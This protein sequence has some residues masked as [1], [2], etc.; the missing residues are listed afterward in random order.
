MAQYSPDQGSLDLSEGVARELRGLLS[1]NYFNTA[2][3]VALVRQAGASVEMINW[4]Q[5]ISLVWGDVLAAAARQGKLRPLLQQL[6]DRSDDALAEELRALLPDQEAGEP[7]TD[8]LPPMGASSLGGGLG[9][10]FYEVV[11]AP[12]LQRVVQDQGPLPPES[13]QQLGIQLAE[14]LSTIHAAGVI[15]RDLK[16]ANIVLTEDGPRIIDFGIARMIDSAPADPA[17]EAGTVM[18][19][20]GFMAPELARGELAGPASDVFGLGV[21]LVYAA[22]GETPFGD[23]SPMALLYRV[24]NEPPRLDRVP[25]VLRPAIEQMLSK[26]PHNRPTTGQLLRLLAYQDSLAHGRPPAVSG[27]PS[28]PENDRPDT[29]DRQSG[30]ARNTAPARKRHMAPRAWRQL[31]A[32]TLNWVAPPASLTVLRSSREALRNDAQQLIE[33]EIGRA[34]TALGPPPGVEAPDLERLLHDERD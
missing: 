14:A 28:G 6:L 34:Y 15:H 3:V 10:V 4:D 9:A 22:T 19:T 23:G 31:A 8:A 1:D 5:P 30:R 26:D 12:S 2:E 17:E 16:P 24:M 18:G 7:Q 20:P 29:P 27:A 13:V 11:D 21:V 33:A 25:D 32:L